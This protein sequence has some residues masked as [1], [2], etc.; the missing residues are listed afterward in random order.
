MTRSGPVAGS[1]VEAARP[2]AG[3][4]IKHKAAFVLLISMAIVNRKTK[5]GIFNKY[6]IDYM[7]KNVFKI[8][9]LGFTI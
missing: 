2:Y 6:A 3:V 1:G 9:C 4:F 5:I 7:K 8:F